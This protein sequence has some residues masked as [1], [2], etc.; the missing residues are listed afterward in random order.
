MTSEQKAPLIQEISVPYENFRKVVGWLSDEEVLIH[1]GET[2]T[3][4]DSL[5]IYQIFTGE[6]KLLCEVDE[7][8]LSV[9]ISEDQK[10]VLFQTLGGESGAVQIIDLSGELVQKKRIE[11]NGFVNVNWNPIDQNH[12]FISYYRGENEATVL[13]WDIEK[14]EMNTVNSSSITPDWYSENLYLYVDNLE[15]FSLETGELYLGDIRTDE[16]LRLKGEVSDFF[17]HDDTFISFSPS[18]FNDQELLLNRQYP[19]MIDNG[20]VDIPKA[21]INGRLIFPQLTQSQRNGVIY[22]IVPKK[23]VRMEIE[24]GEFEFAKL[25]F[26]EREIVPVLDLEDNAPISISD[27]ERYS[28]YGWRFENIIDIKEKELIPFAPVPE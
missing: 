18:D 19:F 4:D 2:A 27:N 7:L 25:D 10:Q 23:A 8:I 1:T 13:N 3:N 26:D 16:V 28:L 22:G 17:L 24:T 6:L 14:N 12:V 20:F 9:A 11:A 15:D 21:S 5:F